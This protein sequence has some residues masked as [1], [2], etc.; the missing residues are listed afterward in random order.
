MDD[1]ITP[2]DDTAEYK[3]NESEGTDLGVTASEQQNSDSV[4]A[5]E[6]LP[7]SRFNLKN[8]NWKRFAAPG[9][10]VLSIM[11]LY[12]AFSFYASRKTSMAEQQKIMSQGNATVV[13]Q[14]IVL[15]TKPKAPV[16]MDVGVSSDQITQMQN[17]LQQE[18]DNMVQQ[19]KNSQ[20]SVS[21]LNSGMFKTQQDIST[22]GQQ[23]E[24]LTMAMQQML[25]EMEK[26]KAPKVKTKKPVFKLPVAYHVRAIVPGRVW[27]E[28]ADGKSVTLRVG[29]KLE[30]YGVVRVISPRQGM[31]IMSNGSIIQ[32]GVNDF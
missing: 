9:I 7:S 10:V 12:G 3:F 23:V 29:D 6:M 4:T 24:Q 5:E 31:V 15:D 19:I 28:S 22:I 25:V 20:D 30:G 26:L 1:K 17:T 21:S 16:T 18:I 13:Q 14:P 27:L 32:Y 8:I 2:P 11:V